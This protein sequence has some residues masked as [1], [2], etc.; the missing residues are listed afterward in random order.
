MFFAGA[1]RVPAAADDTPRIF[2]HSPAALKGVRRAVA[3]AD[4]ACAAA[5]AALR[6]DADAAMKAP[7][8][9]VMDKSQVPPSGDKHDYMSL[10]R[11]YWP[12]PTK[13]G[14]LPY[15]QKD[16]Q[17][18]PE[19]A[20]ITDSHHFGRMQ[21][22]ASTL[23]LAFYLT[24]EAR[25]GEQA[26][27]QLRA[28]FVAPATRMNPNL[29]FGQGVKGRNAGRP[30]GLIE[31][32]ALSQVVDAA[33]LI[34]GS[35][36]WTAKDQ[37]ELLEWFRAYL[38]W[39]QTSAIGRGEAAAANNHGVWYDVQVASIALFTGRTEVARQVLERARTGRI[40][41][42][43]EPDGRM[44]RELQRTLSQHYTWF[45][46]EAFAALAAL[47]ERVDVDLWNYVTRD[48]RGLRTAFAFAL[49]GL[50]GQRSWT[51]P[52]I[53]PFRPGD[54]YAVL[55]EAARRYPDLGLDAI[56]AKVADG[57]RAGDRAHLWL[58]TGFSGLPSLHRLHHAAHAV[59]VVVVHDGLHEAGPAAHRHPDHAR[60]PLS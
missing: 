27:R 11:Y 39:L 36:A 4:P 14:G 37:K 6:A 21:G 9:S 35:P 12:D 47:G 23:A 5:I 45:N 26:A 1:V 8:G 29:N 52:Q 25:Y 57:G 33:G 32:R 28:W 50:A 7:I 22:A 18:N 56:A 34:Q 24:G 40:G 15:I 42:Q 55:L 44:P 10:G 48:G 19:I 58:G 17:V 46:L 54:H 30:S 31:T 60:K 43:I 49:P 13:P 38:D 53:Q 16:G 51:Y 2:F 20:S 59:R 3:A 41:V